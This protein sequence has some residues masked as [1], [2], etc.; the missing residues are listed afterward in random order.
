MGIAANLFFSNAESENCLAYRVKP[1]DEQREA[2]QERWND[3]RDVLQERLKAKSG[4][5]ISS[6]L[7]GSYKFG[8]QIRPTKSGDEF[9]IDLGIYYEWTGSAQDGDYD[10]VE[11]KQFVQEALI[12]YAAD[13]SNESEGTSD[14]KTRCNRIRFSGDFHIDVP[15]YHLDRSCDDR[16][17]ATEDNDWENSDPKAI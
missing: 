6:W 7:Q 17:L 15:S 4:Y 1:A 9:D 3:L 5:T 2:Q 10:P 13:D 12:D 16:S 8:T 11:L 14:P